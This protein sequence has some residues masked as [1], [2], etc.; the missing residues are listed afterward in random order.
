[1]NHFYKCSKST[2]Y[3]L[4]LC[5]KK[6]VGTFLL[7]LLLCCI[8]KSTHAQAPLL[9]KRISISTGKV[10][11]QEA[12]KGLEKSAGCSFAFSNNILKDKPSVHL[13]YTNTPLL[14]IL[15]DLLAVDQEQLLVEGHTIH[16]R[17]RS[18]RTKP[19]T[20]PSR[21]VQH[22][23][24]T[25]LAGNFE[26]ETVVVTG[27]YKPQSVNKSVYHVE[28]IDKRTIENMSVTNVGELLK[29]QINIDIENQSG[30]GRSKIRVLGLNS[31]YTKILMDNIPIAGDENMGSDVDLSTIS[32]DDVER[33]EIV[34][35]AMGVEYGANA[36]AGVINI[37]TKRRA[38]KKTDLS[39]DIQ[40][41]T[42]G[43]EYNLKFNDAAKG[44]HIQRLNAS[45]N[46]ND[47][48]S[49]GG[50]LSRDDFRGFWGQYDGAGVFKQE[51]TWTNPYKNRGYDWSPKVSYNGNAYISYNTPKLSLLYKANYF[52]SNL[53]RHERWIEGFHLKD[54]NM[55]VNLSINNYYRNLR[56]NHHFSARGEVWKNGYFS[57]DGSFQRN[58]LQHKRRGINV[59]D[60]S[61]IAPANGLPEHTG[62]QPN[63]WME[64]FQ[65]KGF[66]SR[67]TF[68]KPVLANKLDV[69]VGYEVDETTANQGYTFTFNDVALM[70]PQVHTLTNGGAWA[71]AEW[72]VT[73]RI[74]LRPG[75]RAN[76][77]S[78]Q[79]VRTNES[80]TTRYKLDA[81]ND[82]RLIL[83]TSTRFPNFQEMYMSYV[84]AIHEY[85]GNP[86]LRPEYGQT[87]ELQW[88]HKREVRSGVYL[89]TSVS[90]MFQN[91]KDR[92]VN[93]VY[94][95][96]REGVMTGLN[97][98]TNENRYYGLANQVDA[99][100]VSEKFHFSLAGSIVG[101]R[102]NDNASENQYSKFLFNSQ[103]NA[104]ATYIFPYGI[105][106]ALFYRFVGKQPQYVFLPVNE[107]GAPGE[108]VTEFYK[109]LAQTDPYHNMDVNVAKSFFNRKLEIRTGIRNLFSV[110]DI[111]YV[112][113]NPPAH[114]VDRTLNA[115]RLFYGRTYF[116]KMTYRI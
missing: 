45:H 113:V 72:Q 99:K 104:Q 14:T 79:N 68:L 38:G 51:L 108:K 54:E 23:D 21:L 36:I 86:D 57:I 50:A 40:E 44:R 52:Q 92:I 48:L 102:G 16:I 15:R 4:Y 111:S 34:K 19:L 22:A 90:T 59:F 85:R 5:F 27:Q 9:Q 67:G 88:G 28:V 75:F 81:E 105:R 8:S 46:L 29:Q 115:I 76:F 100:L 83:G 74:L 53:T 55:E 47:K 25:K 103:A 12:L 61:E 95:S 73:P 11:L 65:S 13:A 49:I 110:T 37:I 66:Y 91:I 80:L 107:P 109:I 114:I 26:L 41:E 58:G 82:F 63:D 116:F 101:Y 97:T 6:Q 2:W 33:V 32:L 71:S 3:R 78:G 24:S 20:K 1:M 42:V 7:L 18:A 69:N 10:T 17:A 60:N 62:L 89:Q 77:S 56:H 43:K 112:M 84:D 87:A 35:G 70:D 31:Q 39:V 64:H 96:E 106:A 30:T 98:Y 94:P 93:I